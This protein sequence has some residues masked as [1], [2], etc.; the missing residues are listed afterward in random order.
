MD[1]YVSCS[2]VA[3]EVS[4]YTPA[5]AVWKLDI[6]RDGNWLELTCHGNGGSRLG[7]N[8]TLEASGTDHLKEE[9]CEA[10]VV[11][12]DKNAAVAGMDDMAIIARIA[13]NCAVGDMGQINCVVCVRWNRQ[14]GRRKSLLR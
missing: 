1:G 7:G 10:G 13:G 5:V 2:E 14:L 11:I 3:L 8:Q 4:P 12:H 9:F 6:E